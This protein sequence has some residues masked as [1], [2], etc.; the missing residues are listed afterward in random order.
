MKSLNDIKNIAIILTLAYAGITVTFLTYMATSVRTYNEIITYKEHEIN[1]AFG[2]L[3]LIGMFTLV[4]LLLF[5]FY[6]A[7]T[8]SNRLLQQADRASGNYTIVESVE[9]DKERRANEEKMREAKLLFDKEVE[10]KLTAML[11]FSPEN[12][13]EDTA[14]LEAIMLKMAKEFSAVQG[15]AYKYNKTNKAFELA[16]TYAYF[17]E[18]VKQSFT[19]DEGIPGQ[20]AVKK[21]SLKINNVPQGYLTV[22]SGLGKGTPS[23]LYVIPIVVDSETVALL[24][25][26]F[27]NNID[28]LLQQVVE[29]LEPKLGN[30]YAKFLK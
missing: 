16:A 17:S 13:A 14:F 9:L 18:N 23:A 29:Q 10:S 20:V 6:R 12:L 26:A 19:L 7:I 1:L 15:L 24:E 21:E 5:L 3:F 4:V 25:L 27:F 30:I 28:E 8:I 11:I 22:L 2:Y